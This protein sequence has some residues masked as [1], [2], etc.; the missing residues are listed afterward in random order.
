AIRF[1]LRGQT[2]A[3]RLLPFLALAVF[4]VIAL[5]GAFFA[6]P[7]LSELGLRTEYAPYLDDDGA[8]A[9]VNIGI[10]AWVA[11]LALVARWRRLLVAG[12]AAQGLALLANPGL[13]IGSVVRYGLLSPD[14]YGLATVP[15]LYLGAALVLGWRPRA[16][17][18]A[19]FVGLLATSALWSAGLLL[20]LS[21]DLWAL[22]R[23]G[24]A[25]FGASVPQ[26][27][28]I[29]AAFWPFVLSLPYWAWRLRGWATGA[30]PAGSDERRVVAGVGLAL[31]AGAV[32]LSWPY[33]GPT[34]GL[35]DNWLP[36]AGKT[37]GWISK[38][39][40]ADAYGPA[41][42]ALA[43]CKTFF[44]WLVGAAALAWLAVAMGKAV[45]LGLRGAVRV[46]G[47]PGGLA[48]LGLAM[49][50]QGPL[51]P[52]PLLYVQPPLIHGLAGALPQAI[53]Q[54]W[55][56]VWAP[57]G[58]A[59]LG[60]CLVG[61]SAPL[62]ADTSRCRGWL[63]F[64]ATLLAIT[65]ALILT[66]GLWA[67]T[68]LSLE[69]QR[70]LTLPEYRQAAQWRLALSLPVNAVL[71]LIGWAVVVAG[72]RALASGPAAL[73]PAAQG[74]GLALI[75]GVAVVGALVFWQTTA[76]PLAE[77][78]P[79][80]GTS[81]VPTNAP[82]TVHLRPGTHNW[83]PGIRATYADTGQYVPGS[84][85]GSAEGTASFT[86]EGGWRPNARV[87]VRIMSAFGQRHY[88][89]SFTTA[90][91][92]A[93]GITPPGPLPAPTAPRAEAQAADS[94]PEQPTTSR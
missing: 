73:P 23:S 56:S 8:F 25:H 58:Y 81:N 71:A 24:Q 22:L 90:A 42:E 6:T 2:P 12:M 18:L 30:P 32:L 45:H 70:I 63:T 16:V 37:L 53:G 68:A 38:T 89:F 9:L 36:E 86:P 13:L 64:V 41:G 84:S 26:Q 92:P 54:E 5:A 1:A 52:F 11:I 75:G 20:R 61:L 7:L 88:E 34:H 35:G 91:G 79:R 28:L 44:S 82:I 17:H 62:R 67:G 19:W 50:W 78:S 85:G 72:R 47:F 51:L 39:V 57:T 80:D 83:L 87:N 49:L 48:L 46:I 59:L 66:I 4:L 10:G 74:R 69:T 15:L 40:P 33:L 93:P 14:A 27:V 77:T 94:A 31:V 3:G 21:P 60:L 55:L 43:A 29:G 65:A 76:M